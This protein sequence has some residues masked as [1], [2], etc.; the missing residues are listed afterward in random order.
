MLCFLIPELLYIYIYIYL[1]S[2]IKM[3]QDQNLQSSECNTAVQWN[4]RILLKT[5]Y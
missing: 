1:K 5:N 4:F 3:F 2:E